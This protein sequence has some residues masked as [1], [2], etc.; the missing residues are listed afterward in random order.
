M[1]Q[2]LFVFALYLGLAAMPA[3]A[4]FNGKNYFPLAD[5]SQWTYSGSMSSTDGKGP[6]MQ[7]QAKARVEG[8]TLI[9]GKEYFKYVIA[10]EFRVR[11]TRCC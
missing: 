11:V 2:R 1:P 9:H 8:K 6:T 3:C 7:V 4:Q 10:A 5:G